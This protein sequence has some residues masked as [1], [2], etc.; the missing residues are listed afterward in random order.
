E[1]HENL[2]R[3]DAYARQT[4]RDAIRKYNAHIEKCN[5]V[6][7]AEVAGRRVVNG[8]NAAAEAHGD[9]AEALAQAADLR[10]ERD[11]LA[12][13]LEQNTAM[14]GQIA[15]RLNGLGVNVGSS[16]D[17]NPSVHADTAQADLVKQNTELREQLYRERERKKRLKGM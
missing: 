7:E 17:G 15:V 4:A 5:R 10:R 1:R 12:G 13:Q 14:V 16:A 9:S 3:H 11:V 2:L 8:S 6:V